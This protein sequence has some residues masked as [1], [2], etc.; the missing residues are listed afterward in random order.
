MRQWL[1]MCYSIRRQ[2][3]HEAIVILHHVNVIKSKTQ[4]ATLNSKAKLRTSKTW[5]GIDHEFR[6]FVQRAPTYG[7]HLLKLCVVEV[8]LNLTTH[9]AAYFHG[10][11]GESQ[12]DVGKLP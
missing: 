5:R 4:E 2:L 9:F 1:N 7:C 11:L 3:R 8:A 6:N 12:E 10:G